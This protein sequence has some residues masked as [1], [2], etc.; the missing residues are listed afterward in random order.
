MTT[1]ETIQDQ[2]FKWSEDILD[3]AFSCIPQEGKLAGFALGISAWPEENPANYL[4]WI[5]NVG[6]K[7]ETHFSTLDNHTPEARQ[8]LSILQVAASWAT[9]TREKMLGH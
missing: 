6:K 8:F 9:K 2:A 3:A 4:L 7:A 1:L 5:I